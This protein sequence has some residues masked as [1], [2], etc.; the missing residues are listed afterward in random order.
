MNSSVTTKNPELAE[1]LR[2]IGLR[3]VAD[4]LDDF[5]ARATKKRLGQVELLEQLLELERRDRSRRGLESRR[6][7]ARIGA[8]KPMADYD[9]DWPK[10]VD[11]ALVNRVL[12]L[13]FIDEGANV[14]L[15][16]AHG[17]GK[18]MILK[19]IAHEAVLAGH[20]ALVLTAAKLLN[21]LSA[22]DSARGLERRLKYYC[23]MSVLALDELGYLSYD[24]RAADLLFEVISR[25]HAAKKPLVL[26]TNLAFG[27]WHQVFPNATCTVALVDRLTHRADVIALEGDSWRRKEARERRTRAAEEQGDAT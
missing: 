20:S 3:G 16:G 21:D 4:V 8:F 2:D 27:D 1:A 7:R 23:R 24:N 13:K 6:K 10:L 11:R 19:N 15:V 26:T 12:A 5:V 25:R 9:W 14:I 18:T 22:Q 17:L